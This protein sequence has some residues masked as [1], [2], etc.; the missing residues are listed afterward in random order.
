MNVASAARGQ[1]AGLKA[2]ITCSAG[3]QPRRARRRL[4]VVLGLAVCLS[5]GWSCRQ[6][7]TPTPEARE[8]AYRANNRGVSLL[9]QFAYGP[10]VEAF[11]EALKLDPSLRLARINLPIALFYAGRTAE[12]AEQA[13]ATSHAYPDAPQPPFILGLIARLDNQPDEAAKAF[14]SVLQLDPD[15]VGSKVNLALTSMQE[16]KYQEAVELSRSALTLEPYNATA[17]YN[18]SLALTRT[19]DTAAG[20]RALQQLD[21]KSVV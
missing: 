21:R 4:A 11:H 5:G 19:G 18:L 17:A 6:A 7:S 2:C 10:A 16:R 12:A 14:R 20:A 15:D 8:A 13:R 3:L 9:E 1:L